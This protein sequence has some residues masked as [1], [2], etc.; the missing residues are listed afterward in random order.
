VIKRTDQVNLA[1]AAGAAVFYALLA[2]LSAHTSVNDGLGPDGLAFGEMV[3]QFTL[4]G[5]D[6]TSRLS[7]L[8][9]VLA[10]LPYELT[11]NVV[12]AFAVVNRLALGVLVFAACRVLDTRG[13]GTSWKAA[14]A[15]YLTLAITFTRFAAFMPA[16]PELCALATLT[17]ALA[18]CASRHPVATAGSHIAAVMTLPVGLVAPLYGLARSRRMRVPSRE[19]AL[20]FAPPLIA[21]VVVQ[22]WARGGVAG[23]LSDISPAALGRGLEV[24]SDP[25]F[26]SFAAYFLVTG[27]GAL[28]VIALAR[29]EST[30]RTFTRAPETAVLCVSLA[31]YL[32]FARIDALLAMGF[33]TPV[34]VLAAPEWIEEARVGRWWWLAGSLAITIATQRPFSDIDL[35]SYYV[36]WHPYMVLR[37]SSPVQYTQLWERWVPRFF[38]AAL[39]VW[40]VAIAGRT[41]RLEGALDEVA[42]P[43]EATL[44]RG[45]QLPVLAVSR[46]R[47]SAWCHS[48]LEVRAASRWTLAA[49]AYALLLGTA[50]GYFLFGMPIQL[51]DS[52]A[53][54]LGV[55][56]LSIWEV[57]KAQF[58]GSGYL[59]PLLQVQLKIV[60]DLAGGH[61]FA[62]YR[63][64]QALQV[65]AALLLMVN[66]LRIR[67]VLDAAVLPVC[68]AVL[69]GIHTFAGAIREGFP[70]NTFLT[71]V[72]CCLLAVRLA[73]S[74]GGAVVDAATVALL[75]FSLLTLETGV[76]VWVIIA[77]A[78]F[79][80]YRGVS[81]RTVLTASLVL[82]A[83]AVTR[84][85]VLKAAMPG[86][87]ERASGFGFRV[88]EPSELV[89]RF[90]RNPLPLYL[91]NYACAVFTVLFAEPRGAIW[92]LFADLSQRTI[93][94]WSVINVAVS[95]G[96]TAVI[97]WYVARRAREWVHRRFDDGDR[98]V[99]LFLVILLANAGLCL[100]Y[101]KDVV[102]SPAGAFYA[103][104]A[105]IAIRTL[106]AVPSRAFGRASIVPLLV[107]ALLATGWG[108]RMLGI[109][110]SLR[111]RAET[112]RSEWAYEDLWETANHITIDTPQA[113]SLKQ[114]LMDDAIWRRP[115]PP[116]LDLGWAE[117]GFDK[118]Q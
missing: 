51:S 78:Y 37:G 32:V 92:R 76:L 80:G 64:V 89:E 96:T 112:T 73:Q 1:I 113:A 63:A 18:L 82:V 39:S 3:R 72:L 68:L 109:H 84:F 75:A 88:L 28:S 70:I 115:A 103:M 2:P 67:T 97:G 43:D 61:Y 77:A 41:R 71:L 7:P 34:W 107:V 104:A 100:V 14:V 54:L 105:F 31:V 47:L 99:V 20:R 23:L 45:L 53:N 57:F 65:L 94:P 13:V 10:W 93:T 55:Q 58:G 12:T 95:T 33:L 114:A 15:L 11:G 26:V 40:F 102:M 42:E 91:Y 52:F 35:T 116:R 16:R 98:L 56:G 17:L 74:R 118:T 69:L 83:Y 48:T 38:I 30:R 44:P 29:A 5:G 46:A 24:W 49:Y 59:R 101:V 4:K 25:L 81:R 66:I 110:Y 106:L 9:P 85:V 27:A 22:W 79:L 117:Q 21:W 6:E 62:W 108:W 111:M 60:Y 8:F 90:G 87:N 36:D 50:T 19:T 86:L